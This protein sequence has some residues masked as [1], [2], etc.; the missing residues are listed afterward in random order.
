MTV[1]RIEKVGGSKEERYFKGRL[2]GNCRS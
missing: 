1:L 2:R